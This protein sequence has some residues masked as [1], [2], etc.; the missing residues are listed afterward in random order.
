MKQTIAQ[1]L[2]IKN[3]PFIIKDKNGAEI[4]RESSIGFWMK[5]EYDAQGNIIHYEDSNGFWSKFEY[6]AQGNEIYYETSDGYWI[7]KEYDAQGNEIYFENS[8]GTVI[9]D[10]PKPVVEMTLQQ[11]ADKLGMDASQIR[12]KD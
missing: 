5:S 4:Y 10:R 12:I 11:L 1:F 9:D 2:N 8:N 7:K 6:D 3:F